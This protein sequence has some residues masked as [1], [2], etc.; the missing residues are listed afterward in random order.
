MSVFILARHAPFRNGVVLPVHRG[1]Q[2]ARIHIGQLEKAV[3]FS[4][5]GITRCPDPVIV[6]QNIG[7]MDSGQHR[8]EFIR[9]IQNRNIQRI[10]GLY[11]Q[12][13]YQLRRCGNH[14]ITNMGIDPD[15]LVHGKFL[16]RFLSRIPADQQNADAALDFNIG[17]AVKM[18]KLRIAE[19]RADGFGLANELL[20]HFRIHLLVHTAELQKLPACCFFLH[21]PV[22]SIGKSIP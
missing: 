13:I 8:P 19:L 11:I 20:L 21:A 16:N 9:G 3:L 10:I 1:V 4:L 6:A 17:I 2:G 18:Q 15:P 5:K 22:T 12:V 7:N 14:R